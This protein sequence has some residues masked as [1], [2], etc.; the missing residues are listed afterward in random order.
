MR[1]SRLLCKYLKDAP[2]IQ[3][4]ETEFL[5]LGNNIILSQIA[6]KIILSLG[7]FEIR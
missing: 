7:Q 6:V 5:E 2:N 1:L 4:F 3:E